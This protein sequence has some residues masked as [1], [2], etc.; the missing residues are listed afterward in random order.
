[1]KSRDLLNSLFCLGLALMP[2]LSNAETRTYISIIEAT[3]LNELWLNAGFFTHHF[4]NNLHLNSDNLGLGGEYRYS[5][6]SS[7]VL[8]E[9]YN[10]DWQTSDY[11]GWYWHPVA[12]GSLSLG[13][14]MGAIDGYPKYA[15][16]GWFPAVIPVASYEYKNYG[17]NI[18]VIPSYKS[19]IHGGISLQFKVKLE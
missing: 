1:M 3:P 9:F 18:I 14:E 16:G 12:V 5:T 10:S 7:I 11:V 8:G 17:A 6:T 15:N 19:Q 13:A 4:Q 2:T